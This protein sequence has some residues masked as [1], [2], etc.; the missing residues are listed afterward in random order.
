MEH[1]KQVTVYA[2][3]DDD[4]MPTK[5]SNPPSNETES[6]DELMTFDDVGRSLIL[7]M[8]PNGYTYKIVSITHFKDLNSFDCELKIKLES[9][10][11]ARKW[12]MEY[13]ERTKETMV[14]DSCKNLSGKM[15]I[16][17]MVLALSTQTETDWNAYREYQVSENYP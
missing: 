10:D 5:C 1:A 15:V 12:V 17:K 4:F 7:S 8:L 14:Y 2:E 16:K 6:S 13:N 9:E 3:N 11:G